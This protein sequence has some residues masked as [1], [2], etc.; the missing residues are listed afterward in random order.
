MTGAQAPAAPAGQTTAAPAPHMP[1]G[2]KGP[3]KVL[4]ITR[5]HEYDREPFNQ[6]FD[7][8]GNDITWTHV[9]HPAADTMLAPENAKNYDVYVFYDL[10]GP[11]VRVNKPDGSFERTYPPPTPEAK[12]NFTE[13]VKSGKGL[14]FLHHSI[15]GYAHTWPEYSEVIGGACD[16]YWPV[17]VRGVD[18]PKH[19]YFGNTQQHITVV[20]KSHPVTQGLGDGFNIV[21]EA[22]SCAFFEDS[23]HPLLRT[24]FKPTDHDKNLN[25]KWPFSNLAG[26][27][28]SAEISPIVYLQNGHGP[29]AWAN[30]DYRKLL[31]N[32]MK[33]AGSPEA[34]DWAKAHPTKIFK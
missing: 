28:K 9:E 13:L 18:H 29:T 16:W 11:G 19:G 7:A 26:W 33:W 14:V 15:A 34:S 22:Y 4:V 30:E 32:A 10:A 12:K 3:L 2:G 17:T 8:L 1:Q 24:D 23:V 6:M 27:V 20:D 21:D 25:P 31:L 5:G